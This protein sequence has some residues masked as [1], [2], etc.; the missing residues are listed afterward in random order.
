MQPISIEK[1]AERFVRENKSENKHQVIKNLK[2]A[3]NRKENGATCI[4]C[5]QAI[6]AIGSA[7]T[8]T[9]M[10]FS[11]TTGEADSSDDYEI[12]KVCHI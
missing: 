2:S 10:C 5:S 11:C 1:F 12:D 3:A 6:W 8:G 9:D 7:I 4:V